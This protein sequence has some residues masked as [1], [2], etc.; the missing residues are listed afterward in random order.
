MEDLNVTLSEGHEGDV[1]LNEE[2]QPKVDP[3]EDDKHP[4]KDVKVETHACDICEKVFTK[5]G[6]KSLHLRKA[7][8][9][10]TMQYTPAPG[11]E[12]NRE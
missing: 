11:E 10:N 3:E 12:E 7:H 9:I 5:I 8:N 1:K 4:K 6:Q 2:S